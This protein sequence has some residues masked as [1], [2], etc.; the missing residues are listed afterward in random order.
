M[1]T[2]K[3][4]KQVNSD[5]RNRGT[6]YYYQ[7]RVDIL[8]GN[9][10]AVRARVRGSSRYEVLL[11]VIR[12]G[13]R[14]YLKSFCDCPYFADRLSPCKH[15]WAVVLAA[16]RS[17]FLQGT[18]RGGPT[19]LD[20]DEDL[21]GDDIWNGAISSATPVAR[22]KS[23]PAGWRANLQAI[24]SRSV[25]LDA[26]IDRRRIVYMVKFEDS[27]TNDELAI[28]FFQQFQ[29][30]DG[31]WSDIRSEAISTYLMPSFNDALDRT[32]LEMLHKTEQ[33]RSN[34][35][36]YSSYGH[37]REP[38]VSFNSA[39]LTPAQ[40]VVLFPLMCETGRCFRRPKNFDIKYVSAFQADPARALKWQDGPPWQFAIRVALAEN[41]KHYVAEG[42]LR[43]G[44][45]RLPLAEAVLLLPGSLVFWDDSAAR[46]EGGPQKSWMQAL[47]K[48]GP[49]PVPAGDKDDF[50]RELLQQPNL[51]PL[52]LPEELR[53]TET[54]VVPK[55][56][57]HVSFKDHPYLRDGSRLKCEL[58]AEY[59]GQT[60]ATKD[61][62][63]SVFDVEKRELIR[64]D[65]IAESA[66]A[67]RAAE[68]GI[69]SA[70]YYYGG[71]NTCLEISKK[72]FPPAVRTL[73]AE[74]WRIE[75]DG[76]LYRQAGSFQFN[77]ASGIDWFELEG[78]V[79]FEGQSLP[80]PRILAALRHK[81]TMVQ[82]DDGSFGML[83]EEWLKKYAV[84]AAVGQAAGDNLKFTRAQV[85]LL[86]ALL[87]AQPQA[88]FDE[89][90]R[91]A[92]DQFRSFAGIEPSEASEDFHGELRGYQKD[93][94]GWLLFLQQFGFG[95]CLADDMGLGKTVQVLSLLAHRAGSRPQKTPRTSLVV[96]PKSLIFNWKAEA[97]RFTPDLKVY[98]HHGLERVK[99][100]KHFRKFNLVLTTYGTLRR[101]AELFGEC[102]FDY[103]I[104]DESQ[105]VKNANTEQAKAVRLLRGN[106]RL[107]MS[108]TPIE[109]H[110]GELWCLFEFLNPGMLGAASVFRLAGGAARNPE[111]EVRELLAK[112]LRPFILRRTKS[113][114]AKDLPEKTEQTILCDLEPEQRRIYDELREYYRA[115]LLKKIE[116]DGIN[117]AKIMVLEA[118]LRL[119]QAACHPG[120]I[121]PRKASAPS[122][123]LDVLLP[124]LWEVIE[125]GHKVL[126]FSQFT[127]FLSIVKK[128]LDQDN[129]PYEYLDGK[130]RDRAGR[131]ERFQNDED[132]KLFLISLK[133]GGLGLNLTAAEYVYLLDPWWNPAVEAQAIDRAHRIGQTKPVFA[134]RLIA[135][136]TVE[137][138][139]LELQ[140]T[141]RDLA[142]AIINADNS[143]I[144]SLKREDLE[145]LLS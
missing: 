136:D 112:A 49:I 48:N 144:S 35:F 140:K 75:A 41:G 34:H 141:K 123:K 5:V 145:L 30:R 139:V 77:V 67:A 93:G 114:V 142:D 57:L 99:D 58:F 17:N 9:H 54:A 82:L 64:R 121:D 133:A 87:E 7:R 143:L 127:S 56:I 62:R 129:V 20:T 18:L 10:A 102:Q 122:A 16:E 128:M 80:L 61:S 110:L 70:R 31:A 83:P 19:F 111:P 90:F 4:R 24:Q 68:L 101:D 11:A 86:D 36:G 14:E 15:I 97:A 115:S 125:E 37:Y 50:L 119:R 3:L 39:R 92:R 109:N 124:Q 120:L 51:P 79:D 105:S 40:Q 46:V 132:C 137:E 134:Y 116:T 65:G 88:T 84:L 72:K 22:A 26:P 69:K 106:H 78:K 91:K 76:K 44:E 32:I 100:K 74:G 21:P 85:G 95:G 60:I 126:V 52:E 25:D 117:K 43:R 59:Q 8:E 107:A 55:P 131:V 2:A 45:Q 47:H 6:M 42:V 29:N 89:T 130:T 118:L 33:P 138:K 104:L 66:F 94:L 23:S 73:I 71:D 27:Q 38:V 63:P 28:H 1:L 135:R 98:D 113:Q 81:D 96:V 13:N 108:G 53:F 12:D 103:C